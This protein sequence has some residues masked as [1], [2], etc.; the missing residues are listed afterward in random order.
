MTVHALRGALMALV[1][2]GP[3]APDEGA[4]VQ[5]LADMAWAAITA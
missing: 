4:V 5:T 1:L 2:D 3:D